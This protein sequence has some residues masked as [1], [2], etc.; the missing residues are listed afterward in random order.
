MTFTNTLTSFCVTREFQGALNLLFTAQE[1]TPPEYAVLVK[2]IFGVTVSLRFVTGGEGA[3]F[4]YNLYVQLNLSDPGIPDAQYT[5]PQSPITFPGQFVPG[6][7]KNVPWKYASGEVPLFC[8]DGS[9]AVRTIAFDFDLPVVFDGT[10]GHG[11]GTWSLR[12]T[13]NT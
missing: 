1:K 6:V 12:Y 8:G 3:N 13:T 9:S 2:T 11:A 4:E 10:T 5:L 7:A